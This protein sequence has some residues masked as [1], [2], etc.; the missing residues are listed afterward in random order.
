MLVGGAIIAGS[1]HKKTVEE[2]RDGG[3]NVVETKVKITKSVDISGTAIPLM[4][5]HASITPELSNSAIEVDELHIV[6]SRTYP[7]EIPA[8]L[9]GNIEEVV[10]TANFQSGLTI[11]NET[12]QV[13][14]P[15]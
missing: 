6:S 3:G 7:G 15:L 1:S 4:N 8:E 2:R 5:S 12:E 11:T 14:E 13:V 9:N 10:M